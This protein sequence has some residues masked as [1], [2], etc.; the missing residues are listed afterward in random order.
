MIATEDT[1]V[2]RRPTPTL[3]LKYSASFSAC[4]ILASGRKSALVRGRRGSA[5]E[6]TKARG[7]MVGVFV[8]LNG[9]LHRRFQSLPRDDLWPSERPRPHFMQAAG[10]GQSRVQLLYWASV[11]LFCFSVQTAGPCVVVGTRSLRLLTDSVPADRYLLLAS[12]RR[13]AA[14][15]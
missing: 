10:S 4:D 5:A 14:D 9:F 3:L 1:S 11:R 7:T 8:D 13:R 15:T 6:A 2:T 12:R